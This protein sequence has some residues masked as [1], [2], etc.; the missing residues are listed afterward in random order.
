MNGRYPGGSEWIR[1]A[2]SL[3]RV[4]LAKIPSNYPGIHVAL[5]ATHMPFISRIMML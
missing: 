1:Y 3:A 5:Y 4:N 2:S